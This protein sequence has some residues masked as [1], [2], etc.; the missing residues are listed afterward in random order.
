MNL[1]VG[2]CLWYR[3]HFIP[4]SVAGVCI[5]PKLHESNLWSEP[6]A[7][8]GTKVKTFVCWKNTT[9][10]EK[11]RRLT[12]VVQNGKPTKRNVFRIRNS[13]WFKG[14][15]PDPNRHSMNI[16]VVPTAKIYGIFCFWTSLL[17]PCHIIYIARYELRVLYY[18]NFPEQ[19]RLHPQFLPYFFL[20]FVVCPFAFFHFSFLIQTV[21]HFVSSPSHKVV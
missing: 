8:R 11:S 15:F 21:S 20:S 2:R 14:L 10:L 6:Q 19:F 1:Y 9:N 13:K 18:K 7:V 16:S 17:C 12:R 4:Y 5:H 3:T